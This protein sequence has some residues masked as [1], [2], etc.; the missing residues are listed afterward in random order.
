[1]SLTLTIIIPAR[2]DNFMDTF[3]YRMESTLNTI[4]LNLAKIGKLAEVEILV[5]DWGSDAPLHTVLNLLPGARQITRYLIVPPDIAVREQKDSVFPIVLAQ[6]AVIRRARGE[7]VMQTDSDVVLTADFFTELFRI[8]NGE[9]LNY[10]NPK[11]ALIGSKRRQIP[12]DA[13]SKTP[14]LDT[15]HHIVE[16]YGNIFSVDSDSNYGFCTTGMMMMHREIWNE[17]RGYDERLIHW[18]WMEIDLGYR[19]V[20]RHPWFDASINLGLMVYHMEHYSPAQGRKVDRKCNPQARPTAYVVND[21]GW[22]LGKYQLEI[23]SYSPLGSE[24]GAPN[25]NPLGLLG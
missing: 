4:A 23:Y 10:V 5:A 16:K 6:N 19:I 13:V 25:Q 20:M 8:M 22:G 17:C 11:A 3:R 9:R 15:L 14:P 21:E 18:G 12:W 7:Y 1:M 2:N 24:A